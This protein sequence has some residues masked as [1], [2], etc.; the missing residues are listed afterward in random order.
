MTAWSYNRTNESLCLRRSTSQKLP[1]LSRR[2]RISLNH[3]TTSPFEE[4]RY[5]APG[6]SPWSS[7]S[8]LSWR[9]STHPSPMLHC[10]TSRA[11]F[12]PRWMRD[13]GCSPATWLPTRLCFRS[14]AGYPP[15]SAAK[16]TSS[17]RL[18]SLPFSPLPADLHPR[19]ACL[20]F[21]EWLKA[22][23]EADCNPPF[24]PFLLIAFLRR[25]VAW[26][27]RS[28]RSRSLLRLFWDLPPEDGSLTT[29]PGA[30]SFTSTSP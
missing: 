4:P 29:I 21:S 8:A 23:P 25:N 27:C 9:C 19:L 22:L 1:T 20:S 7:P 13:R 24:K 10:L 15:S 28:I 17:F 26:L 16:T 5:S 11:V 2:S 3:S 6:S 12:P 30:G 18:P 14:A